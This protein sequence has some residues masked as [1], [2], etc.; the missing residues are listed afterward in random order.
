MQYTITP[1]RKRPSFLWSEAATWAAGSVPVEGEVVTIPQGQTVILD[2][3][4]ADLSGLKIYGTLQADPTVDVGITSNYVE[5]W[6]TGELAIGTSAAAYTN[7]A[8]IT[9]N[10]PIED[11]TERTGIDN[12]LDSPGVERALRVMPG[13]KLRLF[14]NPPETVKTTLNASAAAGT[15]SL[16]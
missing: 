11:F 2:T 8:T 4:T 6:P 12:G 10:G 5:V 7:N 9:L 13:G 15:S 1:R 14:G 3:T 16:P